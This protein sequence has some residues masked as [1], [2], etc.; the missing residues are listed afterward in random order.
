MAGMDTSIL[1]AA[2]R[3]VDKEGL[4]ASR[5]DILVCHGHVSLTGTLIYRHSHQ[6]MN[7]NDLNR[8]KKDLMRIDG[9]NEVTFHL[10]NTPLG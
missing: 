2:E 1:R 5:L 4:E 7:M 6:N 10:M 8:F 9:V 3:K